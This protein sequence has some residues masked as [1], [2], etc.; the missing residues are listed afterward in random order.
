MLMNIELDIADKVKDNLNKKAN[1]M[2]GSAITSAGI[3]MAI[4][5]MGATF[6]LKGWGKS[7]LGIPIQ[8]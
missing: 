5:G 7:L 6:L 1:I 4:H 3:S 8:P 2:I